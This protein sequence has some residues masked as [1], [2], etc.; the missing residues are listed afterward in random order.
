MYLCLFPLFPLQYI[1]FSPFSKIFPS[2]LCLLDLDPPILLNRF[3]DINK[4]ER[5]TVFLFYLFITCVVCESVT[6]MVSRFCYQSVHLYH[7]HPQK[8]SNITPYT[9]HHMHACMHSAFI[10]VYYKYW[11]RK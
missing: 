11:K 10:R 6:S 8:D 3:S 7:P 1:F 5:R 2:H 9:I 4:K